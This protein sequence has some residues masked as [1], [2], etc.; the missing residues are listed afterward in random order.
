MKYQ[1]KTKWKYQYLIFILYTISKM[2]SQELVFT[3]L[4]QNLVKKINSLG[5]NI[6]IRLNNRQNFYKITDKNRI[7]PFTR[8]NEYFL[9]DPYYNINQYL[10]DLIDY[11]ENWNIDQFKNYNLCF[12]DPNIFKKSFTY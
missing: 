10:K 8:K 6:S 7:N 3:K 11:Y 2:N 9:Y 4:D 5:Y 1:S 12:K